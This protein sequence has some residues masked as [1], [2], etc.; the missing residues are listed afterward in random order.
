MC[1]QFCV[2]MIMDVIMHSWEHKKAKFPYGDDKIFDRDNLW[3]VRWAKDFFHI[4]NGER[5]TIWSLNVDTIRE[6]HNFLML[7]TFIGVL[8]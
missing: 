8:C 6:W 7:L 2:E 1:N 3:D 4:N 5:V